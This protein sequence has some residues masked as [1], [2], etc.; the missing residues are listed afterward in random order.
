VFHD[1]DQRALAQAFK[2]AG[3]VSG[4]GGLACHPAPTA[5]TA[6]VVVPQD[7]SLH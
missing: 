7:G 4:K 3:V 6:G 1:K 2:V 5:A